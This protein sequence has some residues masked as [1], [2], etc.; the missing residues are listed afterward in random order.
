MAGWRRHEAAGRQGCLGLAQS[1][2]QYGSGQRHGRYARHAR[3]QGE[4]RHRHR[5][6]LLFGQ[7]EHVREPAAGF[8]GLQGAGAG[9]QAVDQNRG[10]AACRHRRQ[11]PRAG[12]GRQDRQARERLQGRHRLPR[13]RQR[14]LDPV[15]RP[16]QP[17]RAHRGRL[18]RP[19]GDDRGPHGHGEPQTPQHRHGAGRAAGGE[20]ARAT[21]QGP[22]ARQGALRQ[23]RGHREH[24]L[25]RPRQAAV[26][27]RPLRRWPSPRLRTHAPQA[28]GCDVAAELMDDR[29]VGLTMQGSPR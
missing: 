13:P 25:S 18:R 12:P 4:R 23:G 14:E 1:R 17:D 21:G 5:W 2:F 9:Q 10:G 22:Q 8:D 15:Q 19:L 3:R 29:A 6:R 27:Y 20:G 24:F 28:L 7:P 11:R 16:D 26:A